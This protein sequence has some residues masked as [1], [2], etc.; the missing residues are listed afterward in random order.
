MATDPLFNSQLS[1]RNIADRNVAERTYRRFDIESFDLRSAL[2]F[3]WG[4]YRDTNPD[5]LVFGQVSYPLLRRRLAELQK[6]ERRHRE[7]VAAVSLDSA[8]QRLLG[9]LDRE[10]S[11]RWEELPDRAGSDWSEASRAAALLAG[12]NLCDA[13]PTRIRLSDYGDKL[14]A[15][16]SPADQAHAKVA[17]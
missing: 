8:A 7:R 10:T 1:G 5:P 11:I 2:N 14:L 15:E 4:V 12:A 6:L 9:A 16:S 17:G 3:R 13:S